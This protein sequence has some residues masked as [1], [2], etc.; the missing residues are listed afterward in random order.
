MIKRICTCTAVFLLTLYCFFLYDDEI[1]AAML[2]A[3]LVYFSG[4]SVTLWIMRRSLH[5]SLGQVLPIAEKN[6]EIPVKIQVKNTSLLPSIHYQLRLTVENSFT[7][8]REIYRTTGRVNG[9]GQDTIWIT[10]QGKHCGNIRIT[11]DRCWIYDFLLILKASRRLNDTQQ[12]GILPECHLL[13]VEV[14]RRTR[15]FIADA[16]DFSDRESGDDPSEI[17]QIREYREKDSIH[18]IHWKLS[19][20]ADELLVKEHG[21]PLGCVVLLWLNLDMSNSPAPPRISRWKQRQSQAP[22]GSRKLHRKEYPDQGMLTGLLE[23]A[24][25]LSLSLLEERCVHM[26]AWYEPDNQTVQKKRIAKEEH[27]YELLNRLLFVKPHRD[28]KHAQ[29]QYEEAFRGTGF[30]TIVEFRMDGAIL[31][32]ADEQFRLPDH[33]RQIPWDTFYFTV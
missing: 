24:A 26:V 14:T 25:S 11:L 31:V 17:Y 27:I 23:T 7:G 12:V 30:S 1:V 8:E 16:E 33:S 3:E 4:A 29:A 6:Q 22:A 18:D 13:P 32:N 15:E 20:K 5:I 19:A 21:K 2:T 10:V 9:R 28:S